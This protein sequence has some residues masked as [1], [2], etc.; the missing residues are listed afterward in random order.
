MSGKEL[1]MVLLRTGMN[2]TEI[3][4]KLGMSSQALN[5]IFNGSDVRTG[6]VE[7]CV[8]KLGMSYS[9]FFHSGSMHDNYGAAFGSQVETI[10]NQTDRQYVELL[11]ANSQ[12]LA[13]AQEQIDHLLAIIDKLTDK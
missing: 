8:D 9:D 12:Q 3:S 10:N 7:K 11:A 13:K 5:S 1:K 4:A 6:I 2:L